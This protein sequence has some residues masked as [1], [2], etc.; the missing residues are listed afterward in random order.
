MFARIN[1]PQGLAHFNLTYEEAKKWLNLVGNQPM[2]E[3]MVIEKFLDAFGKEV[4]NASQVA[5]NKL[6]SGEITQKKDKTIAEYTRLFR[7][8]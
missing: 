1:P 3:E 8:T 6:F 2:P 4:R 5:R 7:Q